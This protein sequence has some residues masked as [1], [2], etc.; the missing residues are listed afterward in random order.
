M[1]CLLQ[2]LHLEK[3]RFRRAG[4]DYAGIFLNL[5]TPAAMGAAASGAM[6]ALLGNKS[7]AVVFYFEWFIPALDLSTFGIGR[8]MAGLITFFVMI[9]G[10][11]PFLLCGVA[12]VVHIDGFN[13]WALT[14]SRLPKAI[15]K[16]DLHRSYI[17]MKLFNKFTNQAFWLCIIVFL[18]CAFSIQVG[19][20]VVLIALVNK[21]DLAS[22]ILISIIWCAFM[23]GI[24]AFI[25]IAGKMNMYSDEFIKSMRTDRDKAIKRLGRSLETLRIQ[26]GTFFI[27]K[28]M[29]YVEFMCVVLDSTMNVLLAVNDITKN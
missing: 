11:A 29:T 20:N 9:Y 15:S 18:I 27:I 1:N 25:P 24:A 2:I 23:V 4:K 3:Y 21:L 5:M 12:A 17:E 13:F 19:I 16:H 6:T 7:N 22:S 26:I 8:I 14:I 10:T 28:K